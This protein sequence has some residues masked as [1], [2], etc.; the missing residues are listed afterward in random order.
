MVVGVLLFSG[1]SA[2]RG[3]GVSPSGTDGAGAFDGATGTGSGSLGPASSQQVPG[4]SD[5]SQGGVSSATTVGTLLPSAGVVRLG[6]AAHGGTVRLQVGQQL[7]VTLGPSWTAPQAQTPVSDAGAMLQPLRTDSATGF[8]APGTAAT[9][10]TAVRVGP[11]VVS[12]HTDAGCRHTSPR[13]ALPQ[14][15]FQVSVQVQPPPG[16]GGGALPMSPST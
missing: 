15:D 8:P 13:C 4:P 14:S 11:A 2:V 1:C 16:Q 6:L 3:G 5:A 9:T 7:V 10:F 12:A